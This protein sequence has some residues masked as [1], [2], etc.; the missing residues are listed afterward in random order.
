MELTFEEA[1]RGVS[2][3]VQLNVV[4]TCHKCRGGRTEIGYTMVQCPYCN[5]TGMETFSQGPFIMRQTCRKCVGTGQFNKNPCMECQGTGNCVQRRNVT[6]PVPAGVEDGQTVRMQVGKKDVFVTFRV[7]KSDNFR[8]D[9]ADVHS[10]VAISIAQAILGGATRAPG[11]YEDVT[12]NIP[13]GTSSHTKMR[14]P[15]KGIKKVNSFG[16]G[17]HYVTI[18]IKVPTK[19]TEKQKALIKAYAEVEKDTPGTVRN[20]TETKKGRRVVE[21][22]DGAVERIRRSLSSEDAEQDL[23]G[24]KP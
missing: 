12:I 11:I 2:K 21:D 24:Q 20:V 3:H 1:A 23:V 10:E 18:K 22:P 15:N 13:A 9:G 4:D 8:R 14:L 19:L 6:V 16:Y 17:D 5:G 7:K